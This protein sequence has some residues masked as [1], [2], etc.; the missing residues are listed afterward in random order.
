MHVA[1]Q[2]GRVLQLRLID[3]QVHPVDAFH[4]EP[5]MSGQDIGNTSRYGHHGLRYGDQAAT[6][7]NHCHRA[8][9]YPSGPPSRVILPDRSPQQRHVRATRLVG[10]GRSPVS[11]GCAAA[12]AG[13]CAGSTTAKPAPREVTPPAPSA[14]WPG[15]T[16]TP[17]NPAIPQSTRPGVPCCTSG[18][19]LPPAPVKSSAK[20]ARHWSAPPGESHCSSRSPANDCWT[21]SDPAA[22]WPSVPYRHSATGPC[23]DPSPR[24]GPGRSTRTTRSV[25]R[26]PGSATDPRTTPASPSPCGTPPTKSGSWSTTTAPTPT[27]H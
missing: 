25:P 24:N 4:L 6:T 12:A 26:P 22:R 14:R 17:P 1:D 19:A 20:P 2:T 15:S 8:V 10:L 23:P 11:T 5:D 16:P 21:W 18:T 7:A 13:S 3:V 9:I 27:S